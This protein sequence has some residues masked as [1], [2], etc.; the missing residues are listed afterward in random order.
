[1]TVQIEDNTPVSGAGALDFLIEEVGS[2]PG[3]DVGSHDRG[4]GPVF[5]M[6]RRELGHLHESLGGGAVAD[7]PFPRSVRDELVAAGRARAH[8]VMPDS[9]W[10]TVP[11][12]TV[13]D[14]HGAVEVFRLSY[15]RATRR[16][17]GEDG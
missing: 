4:G 2:W 12:R 13:G 6:G 5:R 17:G 9:G 1:M 3:V 10:L 15:D 14:L 16:R 8:H 11:I 7:L